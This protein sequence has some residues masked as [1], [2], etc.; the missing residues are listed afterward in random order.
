MLR[1][2]PILTIALFLVPIGA[3]LVGTLLPAFGYFPAIG[4]TQ[5]SLAPWR[6]LFAYPGFATALRLTVTTGV[7]ATLLSLALAIGICALAQGRAIFRRLEQLLTPLLA[8]PHAAMAIGFAFLL[9]PS[10]W[11]LRLATPWLAGLERPPEIVT[12]QDPW[13]LAMIAGLLLKEVPYLVLMI[14]GAAGQ[15]PVQGTLAAARAMGYRRST[16]WV[17]L[18]FPQIYPQIRLPVYAVLAFSLSVVEV[19]LVLGPGN[20]PPLAILAARWFADY[21]LALYF[22]AAAAASL[23]LLL[24]ILAIGAWRCGEWALAW[25]G[26]SWIDRGGRGGAVGPAV[27]ATASL[28]ILAFALGLLSIAAMAIWSLATAW[29][30]PHLL[31]SGWT[32]ANWTTQAGSVIAPALATAGIALAASLLAAILALAC[33]ENEQRRGRRPGGGALWLLYLPLLVPQIAFLFGAQ[34]MLV[35]LDLDGTLFAVIWAHL[36]FVLPY[37]FLSLA[38]PWRSLDPR[39]VRSAAGLGASPSRIF[40]RIKLPMLLRPILIALAVGFAVSVGQYLPT[41]FAGAGRV[42]TLTTEAVTL[43]GGGDRR[44]VGIYAFLQA[45]LPLLVYGGALLVPVLLYR[46]RRGMA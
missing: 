6:A 44:I 5:I 16:A 10:G 9:A 46:R 2:A 35:R 32:L 28:S 26:R 7:A 43:A 45:I 18:V 30:F 34:V 39:F 14:S 37:V 11:L 25:L 4:G 36:L 40:F 38:D 1:L 15:V 12:I 19:G 13:G 22:P 24:A 21:D 31:P 33:L 29:R 23:A 20:P 17:K 8:S 42:A 27:L 3:G 41:I